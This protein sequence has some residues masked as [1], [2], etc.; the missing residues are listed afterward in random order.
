MPRRG[1][2]P[3]PP[4][5]DADEAVRILKRFLDGD[6]LEQIGRDLEMSPSRVH[7]NMK[8]YGHFT[9]NE[10]RVHWVNLAKRKQ[11]SQ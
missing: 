5:F 1:P 10:R 2:D 11:L 3:D 7:H 6:T 4:A 8:K 9:A